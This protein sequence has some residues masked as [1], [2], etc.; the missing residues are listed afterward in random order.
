MIDQLRGTGVALVTP[1]SNDKD[2]DFTA[3]EKLIEYHIANGTNYLVI[4]G[5]TGETATLSDMERYAILDFVQK[6][7]AGRI[8]LVAG[9]GGNDTMHVLKAFKDYDPSVFTAILSVTPYYNKPNARGLYAHYEMLANNCDTPIILYNVP[10]RTGVNM[11]VE[12]TLKLATDFKNIIG[13]K[14]ASDD[15]DKC[16]NLVRYKPEDFLI[17]SGDDNLILPQMACGMDGVIS[18]IANAY[19][20]AI[21]TLI[22]HGLNNEVAEARAL[23]FKMLNIIRLIFAEGNPVGIKACMAAQN[24]LQNEIRL[25]LVTASESLTDKINEAVKELEKAGII[26]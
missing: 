6:K 1:F 22:N 9:Y 3:L 7:A 10:G 18:V 19:P 5:T 23:H 15:I 4:L 16:M 24:L 17:L 21:S 11:S 25:P 13:I 14:E 12:T 26:C 8:P 20:K 2:I